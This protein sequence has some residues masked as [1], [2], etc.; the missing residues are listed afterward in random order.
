MV[1]NGFVEG[2]LVPF[3]PSH[4]NHTYQQSWIAQDSPVVKLSHRGTMLC[5]GNGLLSLQMAYFYVNHAVHL[6]N[7]QIPQLIYIHIQYVCV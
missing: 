3:S 6:Y 1:H 4:Y 2:F 5:P 7:M